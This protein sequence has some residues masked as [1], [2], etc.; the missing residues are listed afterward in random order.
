MIIPLRAHSANGSLKRS[1][2]N[3]D[4]YIKKAVDVG[5]THLTLTDYSSMS[6]S[7]E[8]YS[9]CIKAGITPI[10]GIEIEIINTVNINLYGNKYRVVLLA[11]NYNGYQRLIKIH[12][13]IKL[14]KNSYINMQDVY[15][16]GGNDLIA[17]F[18]CSINPV[19]MAEAYNDIN[20]IEYML[21]I[22]YNI[23]DDVCFGIH[24]CNN[25][26]YKYVNTVYLKLEEKFKIKTVIDS[27]IYYLNE[28]DYIKHNLHLKS[29]MNDNNI[30]SFIIKDNSHFFM[31]DSDIYNIDC[32]ISKENLYRIINMTNNIANKCNVNIKIDFSLPKYKKIPLK[33]NNDIDA[34]LT[35]LCM[36]ALFKKACCIAN[37]DIYMDRLRYEL[38]VISKLNFSGY[39]LI[40]WDIIKYAKENNIAIGPGRGSCGGSIVS[41]LLGITVADP[42][43]YNLLFERFLSIYRT[44]IPDIDID[45]CSSDRNKL[46]HYVVDTYGKDYCLLVP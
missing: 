13:K 6:A 14:G 4:E 33:Y 16:I 39:F 23:F 18:P 8:F 7:I 27:D 32:D 11:K 25:E 34:Y 43:K 29:I 45:V 9:K 20:T 40:V 19:V 37:P 2:L 5:L 35:D 42:I 22:Y 41:W 21:N 12:N 17:L 3:I 28:S 30:S 24:P 44:D 26:N 1:V 10:I 15:N 31:T 36:D 46:K 38:Y